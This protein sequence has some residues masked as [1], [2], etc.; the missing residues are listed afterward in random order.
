MDAQM[1]GG[2][3]DRADT[4]LV[5]AAATKPAAPAAVKGQVV[6][7]LVAQ[8][9]LGLRRVEGVLAHLAGV[10]RPECGRR[11][12]R[13]RRAGGVLP[14]ILVVADRRIE[15]ELLGE[16]VDRIAEH[17]PGVV[18]LRVR[19]EGRVRVVANGLAGSTSGVS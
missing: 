7:W 8:R 5:E 4:G 10:R 11:Q 1:A 2:G 17:G 18:V 12:E 15:L 3:R 16:L 14:L 9:A 19:Q 6:G 13:G